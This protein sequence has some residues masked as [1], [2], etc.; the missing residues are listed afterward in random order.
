MIPPAAFAAVLIAMLAAAAGAQS[1]GDGSQTG[2]GSTP[3]TGLAHAPEANMFLGAATTSIPF[4]VPPGRKNITPKLELT[5]NSNGGP[6]PYGYGWDLSLPRIQRATKQG[7]RTCGALRD[8]YVLTLPSGTIECTMVAGGRCKPHAEEAFVK[9]V[10]VVVWDGSKNR[11][12]WDV[13]DKSGTHYKFGGNSASINGDGSFT[14]PARTGDDPYEGTSGCGFG[15]SWGLTSIDDPNGNRLDVQYLL[16]DDT[17]YP[18]TIRYG[19]NGGLAHMFEVGFEWEARDDDLVSGMGGIPAVLSKRLFRVEV[20]HTG[21]QVR[22]YRLTYVPGRVGRQTFLQS[23]TLADA[24][25]NTLLRADGQAAASTFTYHAKTAGFAD[26]AQVPPRPALGTNPSYFRWIETEETVHTTYRDVLDVDGD[27]YPDLVAANQCPAGNGW[28][29]YLGC[30]R[31]AGGSCMP[32]QGSFATAPISWYVPDTGPMTIMCSLSQSVDGSPTHTSW[33]TVDLTGDGIPDF[34]DAR[35]AQWKVYPG[36]P[37]SASGGWGFGTEQSWP[38]PAAYTQVSGQRTIF[39]SG[40]DNNWEGKAVRQDLID[41]TGDGRLD[42]VQSPGNDD[43]GGSTIYDPLNTAVWTIY[44]NTQGLRY[45]AGNQHG[46]AGLQLRPA[47]PRTRCLRQA[48]RGRVRHLA[49][50]HR[51][52]RLWRGAELQEC[53]LRQ[54]HPQRA[55]RRLSTLRAIPNLSRLIRP[56]RRPLATRA[57]RPQQQPVRPTLPDALPA[58]C[59]E[60]CQLRSKNPRTRCGGRGGGR[61]WQA[62]RIDPGSLGARAEHCCSRPYVG[63]NQRP[64]HRFRCRRTNIWLLRRGGMEQPGIS[65]AVA[66]RLIEPRSRRRGVAA[67]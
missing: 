45:D 40:S 14:A 12:T 50:S 66:T 61:R 1:R 34:V 67:V 5:Y 24:Y 51:R 18:D 48:R 65:D 7:A 59:L 15:A 21:Q 16:E 6:S 46:A 26:T 44:P 37:Q 32:N 52:H 20:R 33:A 3:Y 19:G 31:D 23:V 36:T 41:M 55:P 62:D 27:G 25:D 56:R 9:I 42:L 22:A 64:N 28:H 54:R 35:S 57:T 4:L 30:K 8:E 53:R 17:L 49:H 58:R 63:C 39:N 38:A 10:A 13:W 43:S 60:Q 29:V 47:N 11:I 2:D